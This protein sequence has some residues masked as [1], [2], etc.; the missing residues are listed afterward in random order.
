MSLSPSKRFVWVCVWLNCV[1]VFVCLFVCFF[2]CVCVGC[3]WVSLCTCVCVCVSLYVKIWNSIDSFW[4]IFIHDS[5]NEKLPTRRRKY[6]FAVVGWCFRCAEQS[7]WSCAMVL[8]AHGETRTRATLRFGASD[9]PKQLK[10]TW[11][12]FDC[13]LLLCIANGLIRTLSTWRL[14][15]FF[16]F[17]HWHLIVLAVLLLFFEFLKACGSAYHSKRCSTVT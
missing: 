4:F 7:N 8:P 9:L 6:H 3:E 10:Y 14:S 12:F 1:W 5:C 17:A 2:V 13:V 16:C 11:S 15:C